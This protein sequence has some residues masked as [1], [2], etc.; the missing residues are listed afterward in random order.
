[1]LPF[2]NCF[3]FNCISCLHTS[4]NGYKE[5]WEQGKWW[6]ERERKGIIFSQ[7]LPLPNSHTHTQACAHTHTHTHPMSLNI[8][9]FSKPFKM[10]QSPSPPSKIPTH[11]SRFRSNATSSIKSS[12]KSHTILIVPAS[13]YQCYLVQVA[14]YSIYQIMVGDVSL[15]LSCRCLDNRDCVWCIFT[16]IPILKE[17]WVIGTH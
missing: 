3:L 15:L 16:S 14:R 5:V 9:S 6:K 4:G 1:M 13:P 8:H 10:Y 11:P 2:S 12:L 17:V 7:F